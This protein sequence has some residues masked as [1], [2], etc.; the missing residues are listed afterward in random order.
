MSLPVCPNPACAELAPLDALYCLECGSQLLLDNRAVSRY[1]W[2]MADL[3]SSAGHGARRDSAT[4][5]NKS[6][7]ETLRRSSLS[8][9]DAPGAVVGSGHSLDAALLGEAVEAARERGV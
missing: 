8:L 4:A 7:H 3:K 6:A 2:L 9:V 5:S 1:E